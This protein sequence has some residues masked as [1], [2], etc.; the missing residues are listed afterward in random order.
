VQSAKVQNQGE[1]RL[2]CALSTVH[3]PLCTFHCATL[4]FAL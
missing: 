4:N 1:S 3:F 2:H